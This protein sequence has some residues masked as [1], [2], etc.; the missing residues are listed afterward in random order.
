MQLTLNRSEALIAAYT[1]GYHD[2]LSLSPKQVEALGILSDKE[3]MALT[4]GGAA[5]GGKSWLGCEWVILNAMAY[6][7][8]RWFIGREELKRLRESTLLTFYKVARKLGVHKDAFKYNGQDHFIQFANG[9]RVDL[10]ELKYLPSDP[11]YER[12]GSVEY[13]GGWIEEGGE[14]AFDAYDTLKSRVGRHLN[15]QY[16]LLGKILIT[17]N[18]KKNWL[19]TMFYKPYKEGVLKPTLK[20][21]QSLVTDNPNRESGA[22]EALDSITNKAKKE[23]LR[24]GNWEYDDDPS[25]LMSFD[26]I[27]DIFTN[28]HVSAG[29]MYLTADI[30]RKGVDKT[31]LMV[32][33]GWR[34]QKVVSYQGVLTNMTVLR[35]KELMREYSIPASHVV[36]DEDGV[37]GGVVDNLPGCK[38]FVNNS[39]P[40]PNPD[41]N[42]PE[43]YDNLKSQ[44]FFRISKQVNDHALYV[45]CDSDVQGL[46][47]EELEQIKEKDMDSD[48]KMGVIPKE[49]MKELLGRSPDYADALMM[50]A[51][52]TYVKTNKNNW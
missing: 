25:V 48:K 1:S 9:S 44:C 41:S 42:L 40:M 14:V 18:P 24:F 27:S 4:F 43:N 23:R 50:R 21:I 17:C 11:L 3:T 20:F 22:L 33:S 5:N 26:A 37:G 47:T 15:D 28:E 2:L 49:K 34:V 46:L 13:T 6:P 7:G 32:W 10:L 35:V 31:V 45:S 51:F 12:Y 36:I 39:R 29:E 52:F 19:Y 30:A 8:T 38:G 16:G